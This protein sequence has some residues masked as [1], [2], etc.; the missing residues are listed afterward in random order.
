MKGFQDKIQALLKSHKKP[1]RTSWT[2]LQSYAFD[3]QID[4]LRRLRDKAQLDRNATADHEHQRAQQL[5][6]ES[7]VACQTA[8][9]S[10][11]TERQ[12]RSPKAA[13]SEANK[14][15][16][17]NKN[18]DNDPPV[19]TTNN[20]AEAPNTSVLIKQVSK[21]LHQANQREGAQFKC[22]FG[23]LVELNQSTADAVEAVHN[24]SASVRDLAQAQAETDMMLHT[25]LAPLPQ[26]SAPAAGP[27][28]F[29][30]QKPI[31]CSS[32]RL[33]HGLQNAMN[34]NLLLTNWTGTTNQ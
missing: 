25:M 6:Q 26:Q 2:G 30:Q 10:Y 4:A 29:H 13:Q 33:Q 31:F 28:Y 9:T 3:S 20:G 11:V 21:S 8:V 17:T 23:A 12:C 14:A 5:R 27:A 34:G 16:A 19:H 15:D 18:E 1:S 24:L 32:T 22:L 7:L